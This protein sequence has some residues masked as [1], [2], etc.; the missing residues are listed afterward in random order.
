[1]A[2]INLGIATLEAI[3][4]IA[5][6]VL[7]IVTLLILSTAKPLVVACKNNLPRAMRGIVAQLTSAVTT[8]T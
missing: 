5:M 4:D 7:A 1:M 3:T 2:S 6:D 8:R